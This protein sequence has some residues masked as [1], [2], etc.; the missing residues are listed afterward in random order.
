VRAA[1]AVITHGAKAIEIE[2]IEARVAEFGGVIIPYLEFGPWVQEHGLKLGLMVDQLFANRISAFFGA[3]V[4]VSALVVFVFT[5]FERK[6]LGGTWWLPVVAVLLA[7]VSAGL[8]L[9]LYSRKEPSS[10]ARNATD[11][12]S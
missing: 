4:M 11:I 12:P 6:R 3:D 7:G 8:P 9:L 5:G 1:E 2:D 10:L